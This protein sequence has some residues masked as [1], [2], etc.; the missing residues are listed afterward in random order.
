MAVPFFDVH[1][2]W[3]DEV[4]AAVL[5]RWRR[6]LEH[7]RFV[8]GPEIG[9]LEA[10]LAAVLGVPHAIGCSNGSDALVLGLRLCDVG[11]GDEVVV[12]ALTFFATAGAVARVGAVPVFADVDPETLTLDPEDAARRVG[13]RTKAVMPVHLYGRPAPVGPLRDAVEAAAGRPVAVVEDAAQAIGAA[14]GEGPVGALG[15]AAG[16]SCFPTKNLGAAGDAGFVTVCDPADAERARRLREHGGG[17]RYHH[18]EVGYNFRMDTLQAAALLE[19]LPRLPAFTAARREGARHYRELLAAAGLAAEAGG[20]VDVPPDHPG[21]V[22][23]QF[24]VRVPERD[25]VRAAMA[26][27]GVATAVYYPLGLHLQPCFAGLGGRTGDL[28]ETERATAELLALPIHPGVTAVQRE[29]VVAAL[30]EALS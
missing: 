13:P 21:H 19:L 30:R 8:H 2:V 20:P 18:D 22:Y 5:E 11:P 23:H 1:A 26:E 7:G 24:V 4:Q 3:D 6:V 29:E 9:E 10:A 17:R 16:W 28:P 12:P 14:S 15:R 25:R 27:R